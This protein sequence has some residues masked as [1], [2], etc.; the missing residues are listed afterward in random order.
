MFTV[1]CVFLF[2]VCFFICVG[3]NS[4]AEFLSVDL[5]E[6]LQSNQLNS[7]EKWFFTKKFKAI[8]M[9]NNNL[10]SWLKSNGL[11]K[12]INGFYKLGYTDIESVKERMDKAEVN[13]IIA[14]FEGSLA[15]Y[16]LLIQ[17]LMELKEN[18]DGWIVVQVIFFVFQIFMFLSKW[19]CKYYKQFF[20]FRMILVITGG[21]NF[22]N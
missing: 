19:I 12:Y 8:K 1:K 15:E 17:A 16:E 5:E 11:E 14:S 13:K 7:K 4:V 22:I 18:S 10:I 6:I 21:V 9:A 2:L 20:H 3:V